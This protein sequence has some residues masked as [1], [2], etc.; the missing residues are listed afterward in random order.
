M[1]FSNMCHCNVIRKLY[2]PFRGISLF[3]DLFC[4]IPDLHLSKSWEDF[5][6]VGAKTLSNLNICKG[7]GRCHAVLP[8]LSGIMFEF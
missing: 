5:F 2:A 3:K 4:S 1:P 6:T 8:Y 7:E